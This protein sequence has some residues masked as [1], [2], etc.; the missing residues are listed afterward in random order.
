[1]YVRRSDAATWRFTMIHPPLYSVDV[2][3]SPSIT[4]NDRMRTVL[5][6]I[7]LLHNIPTSYNLNEKINKK[8]IL[9]RSM[10]TVRRRSRRTFLTRFFDDVSTASSLTFSIPTSNFSTTRRNF[11]S[12]LSMLFLFSLLKVYVNFS[13]V[14]YRDYGCS[15]IIE[16]RVLLS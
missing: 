9:L 7:T 10:T 5:F 15:Y 13:S 14:F 6:S 8:M 1:M 11:Q 2:F 4:R 12:L 16:T 3:L